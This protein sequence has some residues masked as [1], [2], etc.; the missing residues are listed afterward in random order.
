MKHMK[1]LLND[2]YTL[3]GDAFDGEDGMDSLA[4]AESGERVTCSECRKVIAACKVVTYSWR[5]P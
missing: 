3:C 1:S 2:E 4:F 5:L